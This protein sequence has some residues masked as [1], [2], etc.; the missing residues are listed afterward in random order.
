MIEGDPPPLTPEEKKR[1]EWPERE[2]AERIEA[3]APPF[4]GHAEELGGS[5]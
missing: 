1:R 2:A 5:S 4:E 3:V